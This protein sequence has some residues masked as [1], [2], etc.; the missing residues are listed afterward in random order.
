MYRKNKK[1]KIKMQCISYDNNSNIT[2]IKKNK[3]IKNVRSAMKL[4]F[5]IS[6]EF[7]KSMLEAYCKTICNKITN[8][9]NYIFKQYT[10]MKS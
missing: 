9:T 4:A 8:T 5:N 7:A 1:Y 6:I 2:E 10:N 3:A